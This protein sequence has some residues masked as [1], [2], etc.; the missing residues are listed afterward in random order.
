M[1]VW[2]TRSNGD[3]SMHSFPEEP[4]HYVEGEPTGPFNYRP[5]CLGEGFARIGWPN[6]G[7]LLDGYRGRLAPD[8]YSIESGVDLEHKRYLRD[9]ASIQVGDLVLIPADAG[10]HHVH[11][12][13]VVRRARRTRQEVPAET[14]ESAYYYFHDIPGWDWYECAHRVDVRW[15]RLGSGDYAAYY[16]PE[17]GGIWRRAFSRVVTAQQRVMA[18]AKRAGLPVAAGRG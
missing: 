4:E 3:Y 15:H 2:F 14:G 10:E 5:K 17:L 11:L 16:V 9:F 12:G 8:S 18:L 7:D 13:L 1:E 6:A